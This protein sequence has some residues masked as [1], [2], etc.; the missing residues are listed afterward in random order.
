MLYNAYILVVV[1]LVSLLGGWL[2]TRA[3]RKKEAER[4][5]KHDP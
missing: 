5:A 1:A 3:D 2:W 4:R